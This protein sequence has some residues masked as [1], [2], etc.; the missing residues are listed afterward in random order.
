LA[1]AVR[2]F[3]ALPRT[4]LFAISVNPS[5]QLERL[6]NLAGGDQWHVF[7]DARTKQFVDQ[8]A[9]NGNDQ[10]WGRGEYLK[11]AYF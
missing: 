9:Q 4:E 11:M 8:G 7:L 5:A 6:K 1:Q 3:G 2:P 10:I